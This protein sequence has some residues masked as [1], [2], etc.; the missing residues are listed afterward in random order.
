MYKWMPW[1]MA[2]CGSAQ[3]TQLPRGGRVEGQDSEVEEEKKRRRKRS[4]S[5]TASETILQPFPLVWVRRKLAEEAGGW[6]RWGRGGNVQGPPPP[7]LQKAPSHSP[8]IRAGVGSGSQIVGIM[9]SWNNRAKWA[10]EWKKSCFE[11]VMRQSATGRFVRERGANRHSLFSF[12]LP[13]LHASSLPC[14]SSSLPL[15]PI[16][17]PLLFLPD[18][19][20]GPLTRRSP[21]PPTMPCPAL[22]LQFSSILPAVEEVCCRHRFASQCRGSCRENVKGR[23]RAAV[24]VV[25]NCQ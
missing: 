11:C 3:C 10:L 1:P 9:A 2:F 23:C 21:P 14:P 13:F 8:R 15:P 7:P 12:I 6:W 24:V 22:R 25:G 20:T 17:F 5:L 4:P 16:L 19:H 18:A